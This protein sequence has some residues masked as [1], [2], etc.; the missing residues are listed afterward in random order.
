[1]KSL[2]AAVVLASALALPGC[3]RDFRA[4]LGPEGLD[5]VRAE[6]ESLWRT[7][8]S[9]TSSSPRGAVLPASAWPRGIAAIAPEQ[10]HVRKDGVYVFVGSGFLDAQ[11]L[12]VPCPACPG[13]AVESTRASLR[14]IGPRV[15]E[16]SQ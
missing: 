2:N 13:I 16:L 14:E 6:A 5:T 9:A 12:Y 8:G 10:V 1:M 7:H 3:T 15:Y 4:E 11:I